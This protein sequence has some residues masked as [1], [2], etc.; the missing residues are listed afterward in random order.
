MLLLNVVPPLSGHMEAP[1][2]CETSYIYIYI[3]IFIFI[4]IYSDTSAN[5]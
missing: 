1:I 4:Y 3:Y 2:C 5:E